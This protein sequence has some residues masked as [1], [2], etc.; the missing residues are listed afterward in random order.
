MQETHIDTARSFCVST[1]VVRL[2]NQ[3]EIIL[4]LGLT[5]CAGFSS[6]G[7]TVISRARNIGDA[8]QLR[9]T[10]D[11][12]MGRQCVLYHSKPLACRSWNKH[13]IYSSLPASI[14]FLQ[15]QV[16][17]WHASVHAPVCQFSHGPQQARKHW[18]GLVKR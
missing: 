15:I 10:Q 13:A 14:I 4:I 12:V 8:A 6:S 18:P 7:P 17:V 9:N 5:S 3:C 2:Q 16:P 1:M 11:V